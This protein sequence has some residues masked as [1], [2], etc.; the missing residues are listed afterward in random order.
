MSVIVVLLEFT[1]KYFGWTIGKVDPA[2]SVEKIPIEVSFPS[3][4]FN[5]NA[6][7]LLVRRRTIQTHGRPE[8]SASSTNWRIPSLAWR[9]PPQGLP[10]KPKLTFLVDAK[11]QF[12][13]DLPSENLLKRFKIRNRSTQCIF[14]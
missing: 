4:L 8:V 11:L 13:I 5:C 1:Y 12:K 3:I 9:D 10:N 6:N 14:F 7:D 2:C